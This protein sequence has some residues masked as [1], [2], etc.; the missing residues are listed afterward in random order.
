MKRKCLV[1]GIILLFVGSC[2]IPVIAQETEKPFP[3]SRGNWLYV[4]GSGPGNYS[5]I[6]DAIE[7]TSAGDTVFVFNGTYYENVVINKA[8]TVIGENRNTTIIDGKQ[9]GNVVRLT[10]NQI[11]L[12]GFT[13]QNCSDEWDVAGIKI[14]S[15]YNTISNNVILSNASVWP[16]RNDG[17]NIIG[18]KHNNFTW[19]IIC[20]GWDGIYLQSASENY[21]ADNTISKPIYG[22]Y[23]SGYCN[24][25]TIVHNN[26]SNIDN[27]NIYLEYDSND[28]LISDNYL[29][30]GTDSIFVYNC[31]NTTVVGNEICNVY[32]S[33][34]VIKG[35]DTII[36]DNMAYSC[37]EAGIM[38]QS[39]RSTTIINNTITNCLVGIDYTQGSQGNISYNKIRGSDNGLQIAEPGPSNRIF[40][41][42]FRENF[43]GVYTDLTF[44]TTVKITCNNFMNNSRP[45]TFQ[46][47]FPIRRKTPK[48]PIFDS[49]YYDDWKGV[50]PK[51]L[52]G[53]TLLF[54]F[55]PIPFYGIPFYIP[56]LY[57]DWHPAQEPY[58]IGV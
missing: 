5:K 14:Q 29:N 2:I 48:N 6:Q 58:D 3:A 34:I 15:N 51:V 1:V 17:I 20:Y 56:C 28:W 35:D 57:C 39:G 12:T 46:Q 38:I 37:G 42:E 32:G 13:I 26:I 40:N 52:L 54:V 9:N 7:N 8:I 43:I 24:N 23:A 18:K 4:G 53:L 44:K 19:N 55:P 25:N 49:N 31:D 21:F 33:G 11:E 41:N 45:I 47:T 27:N 10:A 22:I 16:T 36:S 50:G 30:I